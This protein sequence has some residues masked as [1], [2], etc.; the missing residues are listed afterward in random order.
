MDFDPFENQLE[1]VNLA[2]LIG[3]LSNELDIGS[4]NWVLIR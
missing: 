1:S 2:F 4:F 3:Y